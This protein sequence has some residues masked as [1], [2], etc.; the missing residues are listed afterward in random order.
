MSEPDCVII[1]LSD[2]SSD[3]EDQMDLIYDTY[4]IEQDDRQVLLP[5]VNVKNM[6]TS[7]QPSIT[8]L[9]CRKRQVNLFKKRDQYAE[10]VWQYHVLMSSCEKTWACVGHLKMMFY[11]IL[12]RQRVVEIQIVNLQVEKGMI[13][14][15]ETDQIY[16]CVVIAYNN[17]NH[18]SE[19]KLKDYEPFKTDCLK[20]LTTKLDRLLVTLEQLLKVIKDPIDLLTIENNAKRLSLLIINVNKLVVVLYVGHD[21]C[22]AILR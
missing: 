8:D 14:F 11:V 22:Q 13:A 10:L 9:Y 21:K 6:Y 1:E 19:G 20:T 15:Q 16:A 7:K 17:V 12:F 4:S 3:E 2:I 18:F 5:K